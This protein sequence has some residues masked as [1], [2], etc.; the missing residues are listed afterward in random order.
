MSARS[1]LLAVAR[2]DLADVLRSRWLIVCMGFYVGLAGIFLLVGA[3]ESS[4][5]GFTGMSRVLFSLTHSLV[6]LLPL[7]GL[8]F[9]GQVINRARADG[10]LELLL[11]QPLRPGRYLAAITASRGL[12][13]TVPL[14][15]T[16]VAIGALGALTTGEPAAW[17]LI[18]RSAVLCAALLWAASALGIAI[19]VH[20]SSPARAMT[21][22]ILAWAL[23]VALLDFGLIGMLLSWRVEPHFVFALA[24]ANPVESVRIALLSAVEPEL[25]TLGPVGFWVANQLGPVASMAVGVLWPLLFGAMAFGLALRSFRRGDLV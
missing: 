4:V 23:G 15:A 5:L 1:E 24:V 10:T 2:L 25:A 21:Y 12:A 22:V 20:V 14:V 17:S 11:S 3:R 7:F 16:L 18:A 9:T 13:L 8:A 19:S 6:L